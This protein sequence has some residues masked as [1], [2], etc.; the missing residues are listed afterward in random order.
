MPAT[1]DLYLQPNGTRKY[2]FTRHED[3]LSQSAGSSVHMTFR[4]TELFQQQE[5]AGEGH[6]VLIYKGVLT[7]VPRPP[8]S[9]PSTVDDSGRRVCCK[10]VKLPL[11]TDG[12][13]IPNLTLYG[14]QEGI[15]ML[16]RE[17]K[18]YREHLKPA[19]GVCVPYYY[20]LWQLETSDYRMVC[21]LLE[22]CGQALPRDKDL[23]TLND[24]TRYVINPCHTSIIVFISDWY[25]ISMMR[26]LLTIHALSVQHNMWNAADHWLLNEQKDRAFLINFR[27]SSKHST[28]KCGA[29]GQEILAWD[30]PYVHEIPC[31]ELTYFVEQ[32]RIWVVRESS[33]SSR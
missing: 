11:H 17:A 10:F 31:D 5:R 7:E 29:D 3:E 6:H 27:F 20:G 2:G 32:M 9:L 30:S 16:K 15:K 19:W 24:Y 22:D 25:R 21:I 26:T 13:Y 23:S 12:E 14:L 1:L 33:Q 8:H 4:T 28:P 18:F